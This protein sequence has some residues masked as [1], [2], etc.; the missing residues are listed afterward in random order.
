MAPGTVTDDAPSPLWDSVC[1]LDPRSLSRKGLVEGSLVSPWLGV[2]LSRLKTSLSFCQGCEFSVEAGVRQDPSIECP[3]RGPGRH[4]P[5]PVPRRTGLAS[6]WTSRARQGGA[7]TKRRLMSGL[8]V[9]RDS[10]SLAPHSV[11]GIGIRS[12]GPPGSGRVLRAEHHHEPSN[13][14]A[15][16]SMC[17]QVLFASD[18][19]EARAQTPSPSHSLAKGLYINTLMHILGGVFYRPLSDV[20]A[21][22]F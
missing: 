9:G 6:R 4:L 21:N 17:T 2:C 14:A 20:W 11:T 3:R 16:R 5:R 18:G 1:R 15:D 13:P 7:F 12:V 8:G 22:L 19:D 10:L